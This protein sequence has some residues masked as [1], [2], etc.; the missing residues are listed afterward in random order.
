VCRGGGAPGHSEPC[1]SA[2]GDSESSDEG[3]GM[4][5]SG[6]HF[7]DAKG[8]AKEGLGKVTGD[9]SLKAE[10]KADQAKSH[11]KDAAEKAKDTVAEKAEQATDKLKDKFS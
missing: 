2:H 11:L 8:K 7:D 6:K 3:E 1:R 4:A 10:G 5:D 9:D